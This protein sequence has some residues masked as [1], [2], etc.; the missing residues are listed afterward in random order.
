MTLHNLIRRA[1]WIVP[2]LV[3]T[4]WLLASASASSDDGDDGPKFG[5]WSAPVNLGLPLNTPF[6][7]MNPFISKDGLSLYF[8]CFNCPGNV[9]GSDIWV[10]QRASVNDVWGTP[11]NLGPNINT[12]AGEGGP[13]LSSDGHSLYFVSNRPGGF[14]GNDIYVS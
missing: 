12:S 14:G 10:S 4:M 7:E 8:A 2:L 3:C 6:A 9:G 5:P 13:A 11:Q 1:I